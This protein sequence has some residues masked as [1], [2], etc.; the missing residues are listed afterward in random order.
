MKTFFNYI[1][2]FFVGISLLS[3]T[4]KEARVY[5]ESDINI[6]PKPVKTVLNKG[7]FEIDKNTTVTTFEGMSVE[8][9]KL[10]KS[11]MN[12][13]A[14]IALK[15]VDPASNTTDNAIVFTRD[16]SLLKE[17][18][19]LAINSKIVTIKANS[20][21]G[22][23]YAVQSLLQLLPEEIESITHQ[24]DIIWEVPNVTI[25]DQPRFKWRGL[26][27]DVSRHFFK[28]AYIKD[29]IDGLSM[30]K[31]NVLHL[32]LVDSQ[33]W[34]IE[35]KK[36]P[37]LTSVGAFRIEA[38]N[39]Q[40]N[41]ING[42]VKGY[43]Q[44]LGGFY[45]QAAIKEIVA[46]ATA[47]GIEV[48]PEI[49]MPAHVHSS[50]AAYPSLSCGVYSEDV[51]SKTN[52]ENPGMY[53]AG[54]E[55]T[56][57]FLENVLL[58]VMPLFPSKYVHIGGDEAGK[59]TWKKCS[60]CQKRLKS[61][62][63][64]NEDELQ[65]YFIKRMEKFLSSKGKKLIGW[66]EILEGGL[67]KDATV[68][69]WRGVQ[70]GLEAAKHG[71][72]VVMTPGSHCYFDHYQGP[73]NEEPLAWG[74]FT[75]L[76]KVYE[77]D[78]IVEGMT[79]TEAAHVLGGQANL[80]SEYIPTE[81]HSQYMIYPRLAAMAEAVWSPK[82]SRDW[83]S[84]SNRLFS[85]LK[86]YEYAG[87]NYAKSAFLV[88]PEATITKD[89]KE[90]EINLKNEFI[91]TDIR[92]TTDGSAVIASSKRYTKPFV[93][94]KTTEVKASVFEAEESV[95]KLM[96]QLFVY[97]YGVGKKVEYLTGYS[98]SYKG[99]GGYTLGNTVR[100]SKNFHDGQWQGWLDKDMNVV[101]DLEKETELTKVTIGAMENQIP[102]IYFP[103]GFKVLVSQ[104]GINFKEIG[105]LE[106]SFVKNETPVLK[107]FEIKLAPSKA[108]YVK[109]I[110]Q[111][112]KKQQGRGGVFIFID[113]ILIN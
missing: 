103:V 59:A 72:D 102:G 100:G 5:T 83:E 107:D 33:G 6:I 113:E 7:V 75:T 16:T 101:I 90:L 34:R 52:W 27:L 79:A 94:S 56:F 106:R 38:E 46:Y 81:S 12:R 32:H 47:K 11:K 53:C 28:V 73:K 60:D 62:Q 42:K 97:H 85:L 67:A 36:Y 26:M 48:I 39:K 24:N 30:H 99:V 35:I 104:D 78:P 41:E 45:T 44:T 8:A 58:E 89:K 15:Q 77:F 88:I 54:K 31:M 70:G 110:A 50:V 82:E 20:N 1:I 109:V 23:L 2:I 63:L 40:L 84:F 3:C 49:E 25:T 69:S 92:Y 9:V 29:V 13:A 68:M 108:R 17:A 57:E 55:S 93:I 80:W 64:K 22:F 76:S 65:S 19:V 43:E 111:G 66:D 74:G 18:Y 71:N 4:C 112:Y 51:S 37:K 10:L 61:E 105:L 21:R 95:G 98:N 14:G 96:D 87:I 91:G 86:R